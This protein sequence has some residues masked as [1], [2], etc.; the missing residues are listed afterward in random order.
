MIA[1]TNVSERDESEWRQA[2][3][4]AFS[5]MSELPLTK[6]NLQIRAMRVFSVLRDELW[7]LI[8]AFRPPDTVQSGHC[9][10]TART[11]L[12]H[13]RLRQSLARRV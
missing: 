6:G 12:G 8:L 4:R 11:C 5:S 1:A 9:Q 13:R 2:Q 7:R 3:R 10:C